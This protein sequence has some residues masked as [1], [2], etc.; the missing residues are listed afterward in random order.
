MP[1]QPVASVPMIGS[2]AIAVASAAS[3]SARKHAGGR[4]Q[5][6]RGVKQGLSLL[7]LPHQ[8]ADSMICCCLR[9]RL[10]TILPLLL[11]RLLRACLLLI[12]LS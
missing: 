12:A 5:R 9:R 11:L 7:L 6:K 2:A 10:R 1:A 4:S 3:G 8:P